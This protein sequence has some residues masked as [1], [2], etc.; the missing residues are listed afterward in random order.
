MKVEAYIVPHLKLKVECTVG[1]VL[2]S[3]HIES[4]V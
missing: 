2:P 4:T 1:T 3:G